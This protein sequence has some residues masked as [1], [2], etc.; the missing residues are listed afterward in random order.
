M[1]CHSIVYRCIKW[2]KCRT[3]L[4]CGL[5]CQPH[6]HW[7]VCAQPLF[8]SVNS[9]DHSTPS[10]SSSS[11]S[12][13]YGPHLAA[14]SQYLGRTPTCYHYRPLMHREM[15]KASSLNTKFTNLL[16]LSKKDFSF[17]CATRSF[18]HHS[19]TDTSHLSHP[20]R[21]TSLDHPSAC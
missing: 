11:F 4:C 8:L 13:F 12:L 16:L 3:L 17:T 19:Q 15:F 5:L 21:T 20:L 14:E 6:A 9:L 18:S 2:S 1:R 7:L 10:S